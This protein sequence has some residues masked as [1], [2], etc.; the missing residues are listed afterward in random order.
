VIAIYD[1]L[2][3]DRRHTSD[4]EGTL[5]TLCDRCR[6]ARGVA[7]A[8]DGDGLICEECGASEDSEVD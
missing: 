6:P 7:W 8:A 4:P 5:V 2:T 1:D 3:P